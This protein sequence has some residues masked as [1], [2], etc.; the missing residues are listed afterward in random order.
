M[1]EQ[2]KYA[3]EISIKAAKGESIEEDGDWSKKLQLRLRETQLKPLITLEQKQKVIANSFYKVIKAIDTAFVPFEKYFTTVEK[4]IPGALKTMDELKTYSAK[5][6]AGLI[7]NPKYQI[8]YNKPSFSFEVSCKLD[9]ESYSISISVS[10]EKQEIRSKRYDD[11]LSDEEINQFV[12]LA[13]KK[14]SQFIESNML[15]SNETK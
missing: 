4:R 12:E 3:L 1:E 11:F 6:V 14:L 15:S 9:E 2:L 7:Y 8:Y 5:G 13:G 10:S